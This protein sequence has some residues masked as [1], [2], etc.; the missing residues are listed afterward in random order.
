MY[1]AADGLGYNFAMPVSRM[2]CPACGAD[3]AYDTHLAKKG[4]DGKDLCPYAGRPHAGLRAAHDMIYFGKWRKMEAGPGDVRRA[5]H[6]IGR[7][8]KSIGRVLEGKD[9]PAARRD[10]E[11]AFEA[12]QAGDPDGESPD[13]LRFMDH[14]L[15]YAHRVI[16][17]LLHEEGHPPHDPMEFANWYDAAEVPFKEEW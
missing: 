6:Q 7:H 14:A 15:S 5:Y 10:L 17:D 2:S 4:P 16:D 11:K 13:S 9:L 3:L 1:N 12:H 8:L